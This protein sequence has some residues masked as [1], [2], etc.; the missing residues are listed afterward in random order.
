MESVKGKMVEFK[1][2]GQA[3]SIFIFLVL[4]LDGV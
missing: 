3:F 4:E 2:D 1:V